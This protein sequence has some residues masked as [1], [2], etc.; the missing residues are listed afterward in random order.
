MPPIEQ[1]LFRIRATL[2]LSDFQGDFPSAKIDFFRIYVACTRIID[3]IT[4]AGGEC[5]NPEHKGKCLCFVLVLL[6]AADRV[7]SDARGR[8]L[9][10]N[11]ELVSVCKAAI[12]G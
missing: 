3:I 12:R 5:A 2:T 1:R 6:D 8:E 4:G 10:G 11:R 9:F 7:K